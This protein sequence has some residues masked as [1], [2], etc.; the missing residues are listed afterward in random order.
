MTNIVRFGGKPLSFWWGCGGRAE[1]SDGRSV[2]PGPDW[3]NMLLDWKGYVDIFW[4]SVWKFWPKS[5]K[6][7]VYNII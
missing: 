7:S 5:F 4:V 6:V 1:D 3:V 2:S